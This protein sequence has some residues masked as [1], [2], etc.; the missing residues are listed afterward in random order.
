MH[1]PRLELSFFI[2]C[3]VFGI[4][5]GASEEEVKREFDALVA[6]SNACERDSECVEVSPGC[7]LG[8]GAAVNAKHKSRVERRAR[9]LID[10][11][12]TGG[13]SCDYGCVVK[14]SVVCIAERCDF[15]PL[16]AGVD[17]SR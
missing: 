7:P 16:D 10:D 6:A 11:Y 14:G 13:R 9:E 15:A 3:T 1:V 2:A 17:A 5:C 12:E 8:C 4:G